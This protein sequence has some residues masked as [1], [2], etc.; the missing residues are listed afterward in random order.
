VVRPRWFA[1]LSDALNGATFA[2]IGAKEGISR[3]AAEQSCDR[4]IR[5]ARR[6]LRG[7]PEV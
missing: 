2:A 6:E 7:G 4:A 5:H 1:R 3:Q